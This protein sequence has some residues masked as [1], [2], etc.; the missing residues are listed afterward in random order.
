MDNL[1]ILL[2][3]TKFSMYY[4]IHQSLD[5]SITVNVFFANG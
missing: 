1:K 4:F 5:H 2:L 3:K